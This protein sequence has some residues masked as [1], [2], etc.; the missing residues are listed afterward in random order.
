MARVE[1]QNIVGPEVR[2][3]IGHER[4]IAIRNAFNLDAL[5][6][7]PDAVEIVVPVTLKTL[8][9]SFVQGLFAASIHSLGENGFF[10]HYKFQAAP[11]VLSD[12]H[13]GVD[14]VL[15]SRHLAGVG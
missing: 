15:T 3:L 9:P 7:S 8:T 4:G 13:A 14:R 12:I 5:D 11:D 6:Q 1:L 10:N 2:V